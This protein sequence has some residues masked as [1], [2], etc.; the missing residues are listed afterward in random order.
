MFKFGTKSI[1][2]LEGVKPVLVDV[3]KEA[4]GLTKQDFTV[5]D[6][7][8]TLQEQHE[9]LASGA[10]ATLKSKHLK[11]SD[12]YGH[13]VDLVPYIAGRN[14]WE[15]EPIYK[16]AHAVARA[17]KKHNVTIR[18]GGVWDK[19]L[20]QLDTSSPESLKRE[21]ELYVARR[22]AQGLRAFIDGP[23]FEL[24]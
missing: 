17:A 9:L 12:G 10:S 1:S 5:F 22:K 21:V 19:T 16:I 11:Q 8:R 20:D 4:L 6:G 15:W 14:R 2:E 24:A 23:H 3:V 13:A 18:W 7:I